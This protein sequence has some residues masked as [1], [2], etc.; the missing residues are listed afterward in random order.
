MQPGSFPAPS[1][2]R[3]RRADARAR[4]RIPARLI[5]RGGIVACVVED[6][7]RTGA[8]M[9]MAER[10][11]LGETGVLQ[12]NRVEGFGAVVWTERG[13][14]G[15]QF[16][17]PLTLADVVAL[18]DFADGYAE[19]ERDTQRRAAREFVLGRRFC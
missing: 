15:F 2:Q 14:C 10:P 8:R 3:G 6:L 18:R 4:L 7:S 5:L 19:Y 13:Q 1:S 9:A 12:I 11:A 16:D 17:E